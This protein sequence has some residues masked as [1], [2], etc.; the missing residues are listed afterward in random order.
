MRHRWSIQGLA[1]A[2]GLGLLFGTGPVCA[3]ASMSQA[4]GPIAGGAGNHASQA[5]AG[6]AAAQEL[7]PLP[8]S[9]LANLPPQE[10]GDLY[11]TY[12][13]YTSA[14]E[15]YEQAPR[16][17]QVWNMM[18]MAYHHLGGIDEARRDYERALTIRPNYPEAINNLGATY[19]AD[20][21][22]KKAVKLYRHALRMMPGSAVI[23]ANLGTAYFA[24]GKFRRGMEE[25]Q[26]AFQLDPT[27]FANPE[28]LAEP[29]T[30]LRSYRA[31]ED[32]CLAELFAQAGLQKEALDY[33]MQ[34][35][36]EGFHDR[37]RLM[38]DSVFTQLRKSQQFAQLMALQK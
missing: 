30:T 19:F 34:A 33:L 21:R 9:A 6:L 13:R 15:A 37:Q 35:F 31:E 28:T 25:Y 3:G 29:G 20:H 18:G 12:G 8:D 16:S 24:W 27:V 23:A 22:Y 17:A 26:R 4:N 2:A 11:M 14:I 1:L 7:T 38:Q 5:G 36:N 10:R 32:Y